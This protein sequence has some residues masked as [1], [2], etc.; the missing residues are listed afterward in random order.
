MKWLIGCEYTGIVREAFKNAGHQAVSVDLRPSAIPGIHVIADIRDV[1][2]TKFDGAIFFPPCQYLTNAGN[3]YK[4]EAWDMGFVDDAL[5][6]VEF[7]MECDIK[8][9]AIENPPGLISTCIRPPTQV[10]NPYQFGDPYKK[11]TCLWLKNLPPLVPTNI[12]EPIGHWLG[13]KGEVEHAVKKRRDQTF[14]G[15]ARAMAEQWGSI[16]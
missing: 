9:T 10:I 13:K 12:V 7:L 1:L 6:L 16:S 3:R 15:I 8:R 5:D 14:P 2:S 11:R 4:G